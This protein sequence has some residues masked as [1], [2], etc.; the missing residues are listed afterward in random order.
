M[1]DDARVI[2]RFEGGEGAQFK[3]APS[4][5]QMERLSNENRQKLVAFVCLWFFLALDLA[6]KT[7]VLNL[8]EQPST[9]FVW[10][11]CAGADALLPANRSSAA[12]SA[13]AA[14]MKSVNLVPWICCKV[15]I[16]NSHPDHENAWMLHSWNST[17]IY[18][19]TVSTVHL[20][21]MGCLGSTSSEPLLLRPHTELQCRAICDPHGSGVEHCSV[22]SSWIVQEPGKNHS[23]NQGP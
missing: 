2:G 13:S 9:K 14:A 4:T 22:L 6:W 11:A 12:R 5:S 1:I 7:S 10:K 18:P 19:V 16:L 8:L 21:H 17:G 20:P 15:N 3:K 23:P